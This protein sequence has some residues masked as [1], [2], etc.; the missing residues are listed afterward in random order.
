M[1]KHA[2]IEDEWLWSTELAER[3]LRW[4][5][6]QKLPNLKSF[7]SFLCGLQQPLLDII[8]L[9]IRQAKMRVFGYLA[10]VSTKLPYPIDS[11]VVT[12]EYT[13]VK[14]V[15]FVQDAC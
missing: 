6:L 5:P 10:S 2:S 1:L 12:S 3:L 15:S 9:S 11:I 7:I 13:P 8:A 4:P 14:H